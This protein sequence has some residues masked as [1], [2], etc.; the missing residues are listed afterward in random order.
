MRAGV[1]ESVVSENQRKGYQNPRDSNEGRFK[2]QN[3]GVGR[4]SERMPKAMWKKACR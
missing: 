3:I 4:G 2:Q 1:N